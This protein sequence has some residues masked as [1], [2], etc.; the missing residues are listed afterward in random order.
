MMLNR[1][2]GRPKGDNEPRD[3]TYSVKLTESALNRLRERRGKTDVPV[4]TQIFRAI[5]KDLDNEKEDKQPPYIPLLGV[6]PAGGLD[7]IK[8]EIPGTYIRPP[9]DNLKPGDYALKVCGHSMEAELGMSIGDG[10]FI[11][12]R[13]DTIFPGAYVH[14][15]FSNGQFEHTVTFKKYVRLADGNVEFRPLN[16][17]FKTIHAKEGEFIIRGGMVEKWEIEKPEEKK[18]AK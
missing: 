8:R 6:I 12:L 9:F 5:E 11:I 4:S 7:E 14:V 2:P 1:N 3:I 13:P 17:E 10:A 18:K 15:E 16:P